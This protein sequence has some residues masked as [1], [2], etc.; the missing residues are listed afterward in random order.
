MV[1]STVVPQVQAIFPEGA[2]TKKIKVGLQV[3][4]KK[5]TALGR[6]RAA[7]SR[8]AHVVDS[9]RSV[10]VQVALVTDDHVKVDQKKLANGSNG[11]VLTIVANGHGRMNGLNG[12]NGRAGEG[13]E[14]MSNG[15]PLNDNEVNERV[16]G[17]KA[18][19]VANSRLSLLTNLDIFARM[20]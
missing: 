8:K 1:S 17:V 18:V 5:R 20:I 10:E 13:S 7:F 16:K 6:L 11:Q 12:L 4:P 2:L 19:R 9:S 14:K 3:G 15:M